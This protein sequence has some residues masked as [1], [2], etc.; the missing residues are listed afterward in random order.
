MSSSM[1]LIRNLKEK[2]GGRIRSFL[3]L[4]VFNEEPEGKRKEREEASE[5]GGRG[6]SGAFRSDLLSVFNKES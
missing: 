5:E 4:D 6:G 3:F 1:F 2:G